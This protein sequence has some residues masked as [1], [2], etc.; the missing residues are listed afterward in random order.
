MSSLSTARLGLLDQQHHDTHPRLTVTFKY[1]NLVSGGGP[2]RRTVFVVHT[3]FL[4]A[5]AAFIFLL[6]Q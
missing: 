2:Q 3:G 5:V 6:F 4:L 1:L